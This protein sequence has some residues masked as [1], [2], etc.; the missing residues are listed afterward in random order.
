MT[1]Y[2]GISVLGR[3]KKISAQSYL[4]QTQAF[5]AVS[6]CWRHSGLPLLI[7]GFWSADYLQQKRNELIYAE[8]SHGLE[9][10]RQ[11]DEGFAYFLNKLSNEILEKLHRHIN[12]NLPLAKQK[13]QIASMRKLFA[14]D[15]Q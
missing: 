14:K 1:D 4:G 9:K 3:G 11:I 7:L 2:T 15:Y 10:L 13:E 6:L 12:A 5:C 8:Q